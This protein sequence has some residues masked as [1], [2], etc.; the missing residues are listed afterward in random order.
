MT[1]SPV[2]DRI[3]DRLSDPLPHQ[4]PESNHL[5]QCQVLYPSQVPAN[6]PGKTGAVEKGLGPHHPPGRSSCGS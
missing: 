4:Q 5:L 6:W 3:P 1:A 2:A